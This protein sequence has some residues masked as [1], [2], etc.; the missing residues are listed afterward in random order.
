[1]PR[2]LSTTE[3][4]PH[5]FRPHWSL[6]SLSQCCRFFTSVHP[7]TILYHVFRGLSTVGIDRPAGLPPTCKY[8]VP[9][10]SWSVKPR[11]L[12]GGSSISLDAIIISC[13]SCF[14]NV[15]NTFCRFCMLYNRKRIFLYRKE[16]NVK[17]ENKPKKLKDL[18]EK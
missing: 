3:A 16:G 18:T 4:T 14:V 15:R 12:W 11:P 17:M 2:I 6:T 7:T 5:V 8:I 1:M 10:F 9:H 13:F